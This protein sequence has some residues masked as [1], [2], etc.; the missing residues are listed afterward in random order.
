[1]TA[2]PT[3]WKAKTFASDGVPP[4]G[5]GLGPTSFSEITKGF[6]ALQGGGFVT[7]WQDGRSV[8]AE[9]YDAMGDIQIAAFDIV[10]FWSIA[11]TIP[12]D[13]DVSFATLND[14]RLLVGVAGRSRANYSEEVYDLFAFNPDGTRFDFDPD[15]NVEQFQSTIPTTSP[16]DRDTLTIAPLTDGGFVAG[17]EAVSQPCD[18]SGLLD[19]LGLR[20]FDDDFTP[21]NITAPGMDIANLTDVTTTDDVRGQA[22][23]Y[24][25]SEGGTVVGLANGGFATAWRQDRLQSPSEFDIQ[26]RVFDENGAPRAVTHFTVGQQTDEFN[27]NANALTNAGFADPK[28][29]ALTGGNFVVSWFEYGSNFFQ[30]DIHIAVYDGAG[31]IVRTDTDLIEPADNDPA[32][33]AAKQD[34]SIIALSGGGFIMGWREFRFTDPATIDEYVVFQ[35][36]DETGAPV[37]GQVEL[38]E[39]LDGAN[40]IDGNSGVFNFSGP[41]FLELDDGTILVA[42]GDKRADGNYEAVRLS[43]AG[44]QIG[45]V[46]S[47]F[48]TDTIPASNNLNQPFLQL[49]DDGRIVASVDAGDFNTFFTILDPRDN[50]IT[51][52]NTANVITS[53]LD[54][55]TINALGGADTL[56]GMQGA[57]RLNGGNGADSITGGGGNDKLNGGVGRDTMDGGGGKDVFTVDNAGDKVIGGAGIDKVSSS[58]SFTLKSGLENLTLTG[59]RNLNG[60][61]NNAKNTIKG[62]D[63]KNLLSGKNGNDDIKGGGGK[64]TLKGGSGKDT[65]TGDGGDDILAGEAGN[66]RIIGGGGVDTAEYSAAISRFIVTK[67]SGGKVKVVDK[68]GKF[69][70]DILSGVEKLK[71]GSKVVKVK[72][73]LETEAPRQRAEDDR[74]ASGTLLTD[75]QLFSGHGERGSRGEGSGRERSGEGNAERFLDAEIF[76]IDGGAFEFDDFF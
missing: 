58:V 45:N 27:V 67:I 69:G 13:T 34:F 71:F 44:T 76:K 6:A 7:F 15:P 23:S 26:V 70:A 38:A 72:D 5:S 41:S 52:D 1:M 57:D 8:Q 50:V 11:T 74:S 62:N 33:Q 14:G 10:P 3:V 36:F 75:D 40:G 64:D 59:A 22:G 39:Q 48:D 28:L 68:K 37:T 4:A 31:E 30:A 55:A 19:R 20:R 32:E 51:G 60:F 24:L 35:I 29:T 12:L 16:V 17:Y 65:L 56:I 21:R 49:L 61:G 54:G 63:G 9:V 18:A 66:D 42:W 43:A 25:P 53:R 73:A 2:T 46:F 47:P